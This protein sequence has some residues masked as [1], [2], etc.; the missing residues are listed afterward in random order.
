M[1]PKSLSLLERL[2]QSGE[3]E[4]WERFVE[5]YTPLLFHSALDLGLPEVEAADLVQ[6]VFTIVVQHIRDLVF[7]G[8]QGF[9]SWLRTV[10]VSRW[11]DTQEQRGRQ[12]RAAGADVP[13]PDSPDALWEAE[14]HRR[15]F[16]RALELMQAEFQPTTWRACWDFVVVGKPVTQVTAE[17]GISEHAVHL[18]KGWVFRRL[19]EEL[20]ELID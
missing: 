6:D 15:L 8:G 11:R 3:P 16:G 4:A 10:I 14:Y 17:L 2:R 1:Q 5:L 19:R 20:K 9:R 13:G 12:L 7:D 18:A